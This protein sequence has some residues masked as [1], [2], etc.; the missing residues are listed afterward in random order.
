MGVAVDS[1]DSVET[2][3]QANTHNLTIIRRALELGAL[4]AGSVAVASCGA[5]AASEAMKARLVL[6]AA[7]LFLG[8]LACALEVVLHF[9]SREELRARL[10]E[11]YVVFLRDN[12]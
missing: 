1:V 9:G 8:L 3:A 11:M 5:Q 2:R 12:A 7:T 6:G 10:P 4:V